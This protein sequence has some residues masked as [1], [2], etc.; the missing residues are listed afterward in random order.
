M[1]K[2]VTLILILV[3]LL[4]C[5]AFAQNYVILV[6]PTG[7]G[8]WGYA[9]LKGNLII[10]AKYRKCAGFSEDGLAPIYDPATKQFYFINLKGEML[11]TEVNGFKLI[12]I[13]GFGMK[14]FSDGLAPVKLHDKWGYLDT[15]GKLA[16][17]AVYD[18]VTPFNSGYASVQKEGKFIVL[19]KKGTEYPV[20]VQG[21]KDLNDFSELLASFKQDDG[22]VG[23]VDGSGKVAIEAKFLAAGDFSGG[24]AWAKC[25]AGTIG[26]INPNWR[27]R[28]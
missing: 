14:G 12:E 6:R 2:N 9:D 8:E 10:D 5:G 27:L 19:D 18:E 7:S 11:Q 22:Q 1:K 13:L 20:A 16:I 25:A 15:E 17:H 4:G 21:I 26:Y 24:M 3:L 23:F 28:A